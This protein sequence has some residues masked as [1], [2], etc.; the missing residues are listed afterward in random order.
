MDER[1]TKPELPVHVILRTS[2]YVKINM[3]KCPRVGKMNEPI[4]EQTR[5]GWFIMYPGRKSDLV[6]SLHTRTSVGDFDR[7]SDIDVL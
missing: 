6:S 1:D 3:Q 2:D 5:M 4:A 7:L